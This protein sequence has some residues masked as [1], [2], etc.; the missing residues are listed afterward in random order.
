MQYNTNSEYDKARK[1]NAHALAVENAGS[2]LASKPHKL[3]KQLRPIRWARL[4]IKLKE[5]DILPP[6]D[7][8]RL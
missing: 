2:Y 4:R 8:N 1:E 3:T 5:F 7:I 6:L